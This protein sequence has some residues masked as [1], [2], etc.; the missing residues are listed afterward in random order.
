MAER[1]GFEPLVRFLV[2]TLSKRAPSTTRTS[3]R[4]ESVAYEWRTKIIAH[5]RELGMCLV[6]PCLDSAGCSL[7]T[8]SVRDEIVSDLLIS[9]DQLRA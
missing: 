3:L 5:V 2:H 4:L 7:H 9:S 1:K 8:E 6:D